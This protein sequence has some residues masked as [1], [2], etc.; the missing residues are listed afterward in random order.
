MM[1]LIVKEYAK[2][3]HT[4]SVV[5]CNDSTYCNRYAL[6]F[7]TNFLLK[8]ALKHFITHINLKL[9]KY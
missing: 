4:T 1:G 9:K 6:K 8:Y 2:T 7:D 5:F 3:M